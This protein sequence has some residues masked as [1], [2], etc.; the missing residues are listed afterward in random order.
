M[1]SEGALRWSAPPWVRR[2]VMRL[3]SITPSIIIAA[4]VGKEG[5]TAALNGSQV[6][7]SVALPFVIASLIYF[8]CRGRYMTVRPPR[9]GVEEEE[10]SDDEGGRGVLVVTL[11]GLGL[12]GDEEGVVSFKNRWVTAVFAVVVWLFIAIM[13]VANLVLLGSGN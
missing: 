10:E 12:G 4:P 3:I 2:L 9:A 1:V 6:A 13:N 5:L 7:Q 11:V 8:T